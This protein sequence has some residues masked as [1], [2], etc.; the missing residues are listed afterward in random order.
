MTIIS[1]EVSRQC[2]EGMD[3]QLRGYSFSIVV[4]SLNR[5]ATNTL[6][7]LYFDVTK[8]TLYADPVS[9]PTRR[10]TITVLSEVRFF[11][12]FPFLEPRLIYLN[13]RSFI[14]SFLFLLQYCL[15]LPKR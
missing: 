1:L 4:A 12:T 13:D 15:I 9:H 7:S 6:S 14:L 2:D 3:R 10:A 11:G 5:F 8:D